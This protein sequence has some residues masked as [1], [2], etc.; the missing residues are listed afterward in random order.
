MQQGMMNEQHLHLVGHYRH[1]TGHL[2]IVITDTG[3]L[4]Y[5]RQRHLPP[6]TC[7]ISSGC[8]RP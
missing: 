1:K 6:A 2:T 4:R 5:V 8:Q 3:Q 7:P